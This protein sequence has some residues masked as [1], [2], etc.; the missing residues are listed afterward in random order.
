MA[1]KAGRR[2]PSALALQ[3]ACAARAQEQGATGTKTDM[4]KREKGEEGM[5]KMRKSRMGEKASKERKN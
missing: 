2:P 4:E 3:P 5:E 1:C